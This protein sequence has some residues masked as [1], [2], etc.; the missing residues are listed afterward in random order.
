MSHKTRAN[1][2]NIGS[3]GDN[4]D[5]AENQKE[6]QVPQEQASARSSEYADLKDFICLK[7]KELGD[8]QEKRSQ[9]LQDSLEY[10]QEQ[11]TKI[12]EKCNASSNEAKKTAEQ[13]K[14]SISS[15]GVLR[16]KQGS[17][18]K[19]P[20]PGTRNPKEKHDHQRTERIGKRKH[21][22]CHRYA[23]L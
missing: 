5:S 3:V 21:L 9:S 23:F 2:G 15:M 14:E 8:Q 17:E 11:L 16:G 4:A 10:S 1:R 18:N 19:S 12:E 7:L 13:L 22:E 20:S 6:P